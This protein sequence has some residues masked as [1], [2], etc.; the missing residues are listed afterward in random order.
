MK[1]QDG[2]YR[3]YRIHHG[4][5]KPIERLVAR[6]LIKSKQFHILEDYEDLFEDSLLNG[7]LTP[8]HIRYLEDIFNSGYFKLIHENE[9]NEGNHSA[10]IDDLN[11]GD[12][13]PDEVFLIQREDQEPQLLELYKDKYV[14]DGK[15][16][17]DKEVEDIMKNVHIGLVTMEPVSK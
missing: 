15:Q 13:D 10:L 4:H 17:D 3:V 12:L 5:G 16:I 8:S 11:I 14:L 7:D 6:F 9:A 1:F 2:T